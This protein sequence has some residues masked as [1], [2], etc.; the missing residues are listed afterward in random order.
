MKN[1]MPFYFFLILFFLLLMQITVIAQQSDQIKK[2]L[3]QEIEGS[4]KK[5][6]TEKV[7]F[8]AP[9][10][11]TKAQK[12]Y[13]SAI[14]K[15]EHGD[16]LSKIQEDIIQANEFLNQ[17]YMI[18]DISAIALKDILQLRE[19]MI[20]LKIAN[21]APIKYAQTERKFQELLLVAEQGDIRRVQSKFDDTKARYQNAFIEAYEKSIIPSM[22]NNLKKS[23]THLSRD[24]IKNVR[25][26]IKQLKQWFKTEQK[27]DY[28]I[29][30]LAAKL[31]ER[32]ADIQLVAYPEFYRNLPDTLLI[33]GFTLYVISYTDKGSYD[34]ANNVAV[35]LSG[36]AK[37][38]FNCPNSTIFPILRKLQ[39]VNTLKVVN[40]INKP[41]AEITLEEAKLIDPSA[42]VG[43]TISNETVNRNLAIADRQYFLDERFKDFQLVPQDD[44]IHVRFEDVTI[45]PT[46]SET[47]CTI[48]KGQAWY[49]TI[50]PKPPVPVELEIAGF[51]MLMDSIVLHPSGGSVLARLELPKSI[52]DATGC[53]PAILD[54]GKIYLSSACM[55]YKELPD[56]TFGPFVMDQTGMV[57]HGSGYTMDLSYFHAIPGSGAHPMWR[58]IVFNEGET[59]IDSSK[60]I[61]SNTGY[62]GAAYKFKDAKVYFNGLHGKFNLKQSFSFT[63][64][65]PYYFQ[66]DINNGYLDVEKC[67]VS[68]GQFTNGNIRLPKVAVCDGSPDNQITANF[69][70]LTVQSDLDLA[71]KVTLSNKLYWG[72]LEKVEKIFY[73]ATPKSTIPNYAW[74]YLPGEPTTRFVPKAKTDF[75][76]SWSSDIAAD[77]ETNQISGVTILHLLDFDIHTLDIP[78][79]ES[80]MISFRE[81]KGVSLNGSWINIEGN[82]VNAHFTIYPQSQNEELGNPSITFYKGKDPFNA[83]IKCSNIRNDKD[84]QCI[85]YKFS[86][87]A[88]FDSNIE[89]I[90][91]I[92]GPSNVD[93]PFADLGSTSTAEL[94]GG[95]IDLSDGPVTLDYW[96]VELVSTSDTEPAGVLSVRTGQIILTQAGIRE[97]R[98]FAKPFKLL[99]GEMLADGNLGELFFNYNSAGQKFDGILFSPHLIALSK[100]DPS[101][102]G[103][104]HVCGDNHFDFFGSHY[105]SINDSVYTGSDPTNTYNGRIIELLDKASGKCK[106]SNLVINKIWGN[107]TSL[108]DIKIQYDDNDQDGFLGE[109]YVKMTDI[110]SSRLMGSLQLDSTGAQIGLLLGTSGNFKLNAVEIGSATELWGCINI[111]GDTLK[112]ITLGFTM[113]VYGQSEFGLLG[114]V[115]GMIESKMVIKPTMTS[116]TAAGKM[117]LDMFA[118]L[119][120]SFISVDGSMSLIANYNENSVYGDFQ[121][122]FDMGQFFSGFEADAHV[123]WYLSPTTQYIQG[124]GSIEIYDMSLGGGVS[125]GLFIG[126]NV[127]PN[128]AWVLNDSHNRYKINTNELPSRISGIYGFGMVDFSMDFGIFGG[129]I[130][131]YA[132]VGAFLNLP[133]E[134]GD[135]VTGLPLPF[136]IANLGVSL[137]GEIL[138]GV[139]SASAWVDL[140]MGVG[141]P[142]YFEGSAGLEGCALWV[143]CTS[144]DVTVRLD[145]DGFDIY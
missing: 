72:E 130:E 45:S 7:A 33:D 108:F 56:S 66:I 73:A 47:K 59:I 53:G 23:S 107:K 52:S 51:T 4:L 95:K 88:V 61:I 34:L 5:A 140:Q 10:Y 54:L 89:G 129:G 132:G 142:F 18:K 74:F 60:T 121:G 37:F 49:P 16:R 20:K 136:I 128:D 79:P 100:Y 30:D 48:T 13:Q 57:F 39:K 92:D 17:A 9:T 64:L 77:L 113:S 125:G 38:E 115:T 103:Y 58:G 15:F 101:V 67:E 93:I 134:I 26:D 85:D 80:N 22:E 133:G 24:E 25:S 43:H 19:S 122:K 112:C 41:T 99:W 71:G 70:N 46:P 14:E 141:I 75:N 94:V 11:F 31:D 44:M 139:V 127:D 21:H 6:R 143:M 81:G 84:E 145:E 104:L 40:T 35:G 138:W 131:I 27:K 106:K 109:G 126:N 29:I 124:R 1:K 12:Y 119:G 69:S 98:H 137:H 114:D 68:G 42:K 83:T 111:K 32:I 28:Q 78:N 3:F 102:N 110:F 105:L 91:D 90:L 144:V 123:N 96:K 116:F 55:L 82:G 76:I 63:T 86:S 120:S 65:L 118:G 8:F 2:Q 135:E 97:K 62:L 50:T 36:E 117:T 87:S